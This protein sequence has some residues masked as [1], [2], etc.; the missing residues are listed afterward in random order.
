[1]RIDKTILSYLLNITQKDA[2]LKIQS[3]IQKHGLANKTCSIKSS[4]IEL[5]SSHVC[6]DVDFAIKNIR[7]SYTK[8]YTT[9]E[10]ILNYPAHLLVKKYRKLKHGD[11]CIVSYPE[12]IRIPP[13]LRKLLTEE[14]RKFILE[15]WHERYSNEIETYSVKFI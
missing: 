11:E 14:Q 10:W 2:K 6:Y 8:S 12:K 5:L 15:K 13:V 7:K 3:C 4:Q 9:L 1:M